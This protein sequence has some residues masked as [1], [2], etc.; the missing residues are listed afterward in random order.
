LRVAVLLAATTLTAGATGSEPLTVRIASVIPEG[1]AWAR[2]CRA[3]GREVEAVTSG[4]VR[5]KWYL[6]G[7]AGDELQVAERIRRDQLDGIISGGMLCQRLAP[8]MRVMMLSDVFHD[9]DEAAYVANRLRST[10]DGEFSKA[11]LVNLGEAG[12]GFS[13]LL[14]REPVRTLA[15]LKRLRF[16]L[17][18]LDE[19]LSAQL[20]KIFNLVLLPL[21]EAAH[22]YDQDRADGF[23]ALPSAALAFQWSTQARYVT[24]LRVGYLTGCLLVSR[25]AFD[26]LPLETQQEVRAA[27]AKFRARVEDVGHQQDELLL[28]GLF[29]RQGLHEV[30]VSTQLREEFGRAVLAGAKEAEPLFP[31]GTRARVAAW[32]NEYREQHRAGQP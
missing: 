10:L 24:N 4:A 9:R 25:R 1:S 17:W 29:A 14:S 31:P 3:F 7:V 16:W 30:P 32:L 2:E 27:A 18:D 21:D 11:G 8:S 5:I 12:L 6:S 20:S 19:V 26:G 28:G 13:V 15:D 23:F 22:A